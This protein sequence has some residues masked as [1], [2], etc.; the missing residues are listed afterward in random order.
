MGQYNWKATTCRTGRAAHMVEM[1]GNAVDFSDE[2]RVGVE[3]GLGAAPVIMVAPIVAQLPQ[4]G[5]LGAIFPVGIIIGRVAD[6]GVGDAAGDPVEPGLRHGKGE[7]L[8]FIS[9]Q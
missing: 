3:G 2:L 7:G 1:E 9:G 6:V 8:H 5:R 4:I